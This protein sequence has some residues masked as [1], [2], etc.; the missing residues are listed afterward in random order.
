MTRDPDDDALSWAGDDDPTLDAR[1]AA[2]GAEGALAPGWKI[3][4][5]PGTVRDGVQGDA[6]IDEGAAAQLDE[7]Q[8]DDAASAA[9][10]AAA[11]SVALIVLG[12]LGGVYLLYTVG[13]VITAGRVPNGSVDIV[14]GFMFDLGLWLA[15]LA[16]A[17][18]FALSLW[19]TA[20]GS[21]WRLFWLLLGVLVLL[22][23]PFIVGVGV[24]A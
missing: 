16:P 6:P 21:R 24:G 4:G 3:V 8:S 9:D 5:E 14:G 20:V 7:P 13:W 19:L 10:A 2:S 15:A 17:L 11:S 1:A 22:P 18:W 23:V 12:V